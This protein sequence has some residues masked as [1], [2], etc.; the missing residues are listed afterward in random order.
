MTML[1]RRILLRATV[2]LSC[3]SVAWAETDPGSAADFIRSLGQ[4][5]VSVMDSNDPVAR[6]RDRVAA[7]LRRRVDI[8]GVGRF[9]LGRWWRQASPAEQQEYLRL[10]EETLISSLSARFGEYRGVRFS[11]DRAPQRSDDGVLVNTI[12]VRPNAAPIALDWR[13][14]EVGGQPMVVDVIAESTSL[15]LTQRSEY[16]S[17]IQSRGGQVAALLTAMRN[18]IQQFAARDQGRN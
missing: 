1:E 13:V 15:R 17:V 11:L 12:V 14:S 5:L 2:G 7:I 6:R 9:I 16:S 3:V 4:E 8:E 18:Q 10:F